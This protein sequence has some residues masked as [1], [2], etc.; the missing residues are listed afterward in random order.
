MRT[1]LLL[2]GL[3][4]LAPG[5]QH[6]DPAWDSLDKA[7]EA[8]RVRQ[9]ETAIEF[10]HQAI[11][12]APD[13]APVRKDLAYAYLK[14]GET[15]AARDQFAE[16]I[17]LAPDD[18][19][20]ALEYAF[21]CHETGETAIARRIFNRIRTTGDPDS[22]ATAEAAF[23]N[24]DRPLAEGIARWSQA[25]ELSPRDFSAHYELARL[26]EQRDELEL[27]AEHY[28]EAW[29]LRS[30]L[31]SILVELGRTLKALGQEDPATA[32]L[33]AASRSGEP[34]AAEQ[35]K[36][37]LPSR[38]PY[39][40]EFRLALELD[41]RNAALRR[42]LAD[43]LFAMDRSAEAERELAALA[44]QDPGEARILAERSYEAGYLTDA[45]KFFSIVHEAD[46]LDFSVMMKLGWTYNVLR[47]DD[48][49]LRWFEMAR[50]SP[51]PAVAA[52]AARAYASLRPSRA[53]FR[54]TVWAFPSYSSRW[55]DVFS[56]G[57]IKVDRKL[58]RLPLRSY[59]ST[60]FIGD[61]RQMTSE[62]RPQYLSESSFILGVGLASESWHGLTFWAEAGSAVP[63]VYRPD[64]PRVGSDY[65]GGL[66]FNRGFGR[67]LGGER[68][69]GFFETN[70]DGV[71]LSRFQNDFLLYSQNRIGYTLAA[72][73]ALGG[74]QLQLYWNSNA[75]A[76]VRRQYW[77]N[78]IESGP[79]LR[80]RWKSMPSSWL[81]SVNL[82]RGAYTVQEGNPQGRKFHDLRAGFWYALTR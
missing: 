10:F 34:R 58:G 44:E 11:L 3:A 60:R 18:I 12:A 67:L 66:S 1:S 40:Y 77:A 13:R 48:L 69:G 45:L 32:A 53:A 38:Y 79:G 51:Q 76:D 62:A 55:R 7:Y 49:A 22:R 68:G 39:V 17:R 15:E 47:Q 46:P 2:L 35:A 25:L 33:L 30:E 73:D 59:L 21:L 57:Q 37:L 8:L 56:Y 70:D 41:P 36:K 65:R 9:Y 28:L 52:E 72:L 23:Q 29:R 19:H 42:E 61:T 26:A 14:I 71:F 64:M 4:C 5:G 20:A 50:K 24:V 80:F 54:T 31:P 6:S 81:F 82:L 75:S 78:F 27:A 74:L 63:Y 43:L 16:V